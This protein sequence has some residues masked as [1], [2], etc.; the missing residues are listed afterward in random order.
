MTRLVAVFCAASVAG[1]AAHANQAGPVG[2][3]LTFEV[4]SIRPIG[5]AAG[6]GPV[7]GTLG[8]PPGGQFVAH[9]IQ[10][11]ALVRAAYPE[12]L[13]SHRIVG[14]PD[15][16]R[17]QIFDI[18]AR[19]TG[20][21]LR[22][23]LTEMLKILL[24]DRFQL[25]VHTEQREIDAYALVLARRDGRLGSGLRRRT[26]DCEAPRPSPPARPSSP[27][28]VPRRFEPLEPPECQWSSIVMNGVNYFAGRGELISRLLAHVQVNVDRAVVDRT[29]LQGRFDF[30]L[31]HA[32]L[33]GPSTTDQPGGALPILTA[34]RE[35]LGLMLESRRE[36]MNV[37]VIDHVEMPTPN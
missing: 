3:P 6:V 30:D 31:E 8:F 7:L 24:A 33:E 25:K 18:N 27:P 35:Q 9:N 22:A 12:F 34:I 5:P 20:D 14:G 13:S 21:P 26:I 29:G 1:L 19:A 37:L 11:I 16:I 10:F 17:T 36:R 4:A 15:W 23:R 2:A 28:R 32:P